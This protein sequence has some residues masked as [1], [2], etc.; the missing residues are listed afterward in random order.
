LTRAG[1][2]DRELSVDGARLESRGWFKLLARSGVSARAVIYVLVSY[3]TFDIAIRGN[4]PT[5][6]GGRGALQEVARQPGAPALL[7]VLAAGL[8]LYGLWR[9]VQAVTGR[10]NPARER[11]GPAG[12][13][14]M[15]RTGW[16]AIAVIYL[17]LCV[18]AIKL[19]IGASSGA[20]TSENPQPWAARILAWPGGAEFLG[21]VGAGL[22]IGGTALAIWGFVHDYEKDL[23]LES[24]AT[25]WRGAIMA[26]G[27]LGDLARGFV[28]AL[29]GI[30]LVRSAA[31]GDPG[32]AVGLD[33]ALRS[34]VR[35]SYG[36][37][38]VGLVAG[39]LGCFAV[40]SFAEARFR[41]L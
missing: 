33:A 15:E 19:A 27:S 26:L 28:V 11:S 39:G 29:V 10:S 21:I 22:I 41:R 30:Y 38:L 18:Q 17:N 1:A 6:A 13:F 31:L 2:V 14:W 40:Y 23:A 24:L 36:P 12:L 7:V 4:S 32:K 5:Q 25:P 37:V 3:L 34:L 35:T 8:G 20:G 16:A 9:L